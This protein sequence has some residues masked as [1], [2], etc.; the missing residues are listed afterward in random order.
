MNLYPR[1]IA[2]VITTL[3]CVTAAGQPPDQTP[4]ISMGIV[5]DT[6]GSMA[7]LI[8]HGHHAEPARADRGTIPTGASRRGVQS[9]EYAE[10]Q[11]TTDPQ[12]RHFRAGMERA[13]A[14][15]VAVGVEAG[16]L[17]LSAI[18]FQLSN[19]SVKARSLQAER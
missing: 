9:A 12:Q 11:S 5:L 1:V 6:S 16:F 3:F 7:G 15:A 13:F 8:Q 19:L 18:S 17:R 10:L 4:P 14:A 2:L